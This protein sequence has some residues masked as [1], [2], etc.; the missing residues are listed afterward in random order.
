LGA[1]A[2]ALR[3]ILRDDDL[4]CS[5]DG[6]LGILGLHEAVLALQDPAL[7]IGEVLL[8]FGVR[9][10]G[11]WSGFPAALAPALGFP[12]RAERETSPTAAIIDSQSVK[13]AEKGGLASIR[14]G[15]MPAS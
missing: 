2:G 13:S 8:G 10:R 14:T 5:V 12:L 7:G 1:I 6:D 9:S 4:R 11:G 3:H 15:S